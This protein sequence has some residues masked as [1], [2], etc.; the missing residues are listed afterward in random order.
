MS[1]ATSPSAR[2]RRRAIDRRAPLRASYRSAVAPSPPQTLDTAG[3]LSETETYAYDALR[4]GE[5][6]TPV[7]M[8]Q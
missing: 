8:S 7:N 4:N 2:S 6:L 5:G 3:D 1:A